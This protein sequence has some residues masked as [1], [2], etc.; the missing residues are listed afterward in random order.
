MKKIV[1]A[2]GTN[3]LVKGGYVSRLS[4]MARMPVHN[5]S[6]DATTSLTALYKLQTDP[7]V[8]PGDV[9]LWEYALHEINH[10]ARGHDPEALLRGVEHFIRHCIRRRLVL[11]ALILVPQ[12]VG[13]RI[14]E[15]P[16]VERLHEL[17][18]YYGVATASLKRAYTEKFDHKRLPKVFFTG[19][20]ML[21]AAN[22][23]L[24]YFTANLCVKLL[25][26]AGVPERPLADSQL[27][28]ETRL[29]FE[30]G[31]ADTRLSDGQI[32]LPVAAPPLALTVKEDGLLDALVYF[33]TP[34]GGG[35]TLRIG[36]RELRLSLHH[37]NPGVPGPMLLVLRMQTV[38]GAPCEVKKGD[39]IDIRWEDEVGDFRY[40][41]GEM[42]R[43]PPKALEGRTGRI[44]ALGFEWAED[45]AL[46]L[47]E[48]A[49][50]P[51]PESAPSQAAPAARPGRRLG[52]VLG[53]ALRARQA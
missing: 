27:T 32:E 9:V 41:S 42:L 7:E 17:F 25:E 51:E 3:S 50:A 30:T 48:I 14:E 2:G 6:T 52:G 4:E 44:A 28:G 19:P 34:E 22:K 46:V 39:V 1:V 12:P 45:Y 15:D 8:A 37:R 53:R 38:F 43:M 36:E 35:V 11:I 13:I 26:R 16:Y 18:D 47:P 49:A 40:P 21:D 5:L 23:N 24:M 20:F 29:S 10:V 33:A 31:F